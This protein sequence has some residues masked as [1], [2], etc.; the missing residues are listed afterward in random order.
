M[1]LKIICRIGIVFIVTIIFLGGCTDSRK[2]YDIIIKSGIIVDGTG[3]PGY[4]ADI[5]IRGKR[6]IEIGTISED[7]GKQVIDAKGIHVSPGFIDVHTQTGSLETWHVCGYCDF[8]FEGN[9]G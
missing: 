2:S 9:P 3:N 4:Y 6:I 5:G 8:R 7:L 1:N